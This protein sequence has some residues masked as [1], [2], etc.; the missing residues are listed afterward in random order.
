MN[1]GKSSIGTTDDFIDEE[2]FK[3][4]GK[5]IASPLCIQNT[6]LRLVYV[7]V[8]ECSQPRIAKFDLSS[9][10]QQSHKPH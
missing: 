6:L 3:L 9:L 8:T 2:E 4:F 1:A 10:S 7:Q 5:S